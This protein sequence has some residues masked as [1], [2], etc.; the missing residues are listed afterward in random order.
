[1]SKGVWEKVIT[2]SPNLIFNWKKS[3]PTAFKFIYVK[4]GFV[5]QAYGFIIG[6]FYGNITAKV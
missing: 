2:R 5:N 1:M 4:D 3:F 6:S